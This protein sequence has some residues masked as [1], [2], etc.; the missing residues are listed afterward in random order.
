[1]KNKKKNILI[2]GG[3]GFIGKHLCCKLSKKNKIYILDL[4][5]NDNSKNQFKVDIRNKIKIMV[6]W[7]CEVL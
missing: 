3:S 7:S 4:K 2:V 6:S 5:K 1:M